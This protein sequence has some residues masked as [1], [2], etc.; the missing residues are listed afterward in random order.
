VHPPTLEVVTLDDR[1]A[2]AAEPEGFEV[3]G[4][5]QLARE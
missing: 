2:L 5:Q 3:I 4:P 1:L